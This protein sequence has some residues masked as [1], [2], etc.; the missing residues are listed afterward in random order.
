MLMIADLIGKVRVALKDKRAGKLRRGVL[1]HQ[2]SA[3]AQALA[4]I[5]HASFE[6]LRLPPDSPDLAPSGFCLFPKLKELLKDHKFSN[7]EDVICMANG[8]L[9][10]QQQQF[11]YNCNGIRATLDQ[12]HFI[13]GRLC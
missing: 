1:S 5:H 8:W 12:V 4:T 13:C 10:D 9:E 3:P 7:D 11:F 6:L 2:D